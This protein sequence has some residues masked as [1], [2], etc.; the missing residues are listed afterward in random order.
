MEFKKRT[1]A[2]K[3]DNAF[4]YSSLNPFYSTY[5]NECTWM[6][7]GR[8]LELGANREEL[9]K[10]LP[11]SNAENWAHDTKYPVYD[12]PKIGD[13]LVY[14]C[15]VL[16][17]PNDGAG[18]VAF[19]E[20]VYSDKSILISESGKNMKYKSRIVKPPYNYYL[21]SKYNYTLAGFIRILDFKE[22]YFIKNQNYIILY[23]K[24][25]RTSPKV[26]AF[27]KVVR[28]SLYP[29][30]KTITYADSNGKARFKIGTVRE[31]IDY[32]TDNK[33]NIWGRCKTDH[34]PIWLCV[35]DD[36]GKQV[37]KV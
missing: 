35:E 36:T 18:H 1:T 3:K 14:E 27:N 20:E 34:T 19:V 6:V 32:A 26:S 33:G 30:W 24:Y 13:V 23:N 31:I 16:H 21:S 7:Y 22:K 9:I 10:N 2:P 28:K 12:T 15:G 11:T 29:E 37:E 8:L 17:N 5:V 25:L 4:Y